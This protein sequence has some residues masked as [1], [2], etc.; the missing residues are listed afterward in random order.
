MF[1]PI[2]NVWMFKIFVDFLKM[3]SFMYVLP[4][5]TPG[6]LGIVLGCGISL[7]SIVFAVLVLIVDFIV[8]YPFFKVYD[9]QK[10][11]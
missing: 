11:E 8:Y 9:A 3:N 10:V 1:A 7:L 5:T 4:W 2:L 6:P